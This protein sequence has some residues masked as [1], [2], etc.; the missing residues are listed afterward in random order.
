[1]TRHSLD[2]P[3]GVVEE[4]K[5]ALI[6]MHFMGTGYHQEKPTQNQQTQGLT[7]LTLS[8]PP[9]PSGRKLP[10]KQANLKRKNTSSTTI[11]S[12]MTQGSVQTLQTGITGYLQQNKQGSTPRQEAGWLTSWRHGEYGKNKATALDEQFNHVNSKA[13]LFKALDEY[14]SDANTRYNNHSL[15][16]YLLDALNTLL[17]QNHKSGQWPKSGEQYTH[18]SW[19]GIK[20]ELESFDITYDNTNPHLGK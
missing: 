12:D 6:S 17:E 1:M 7:H 14:F 19:Q 16:A 15:A 8:R 4:R 11:D 2:I 9:G 18:N 5:S 3:Q 10:N 13:C 20:S